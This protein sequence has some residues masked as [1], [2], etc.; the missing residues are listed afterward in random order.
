MRHGKI[1]KADI[2]TDSKGAYEPM[3][4]AAISVALEGLPYSDVVIEQAIEK[5]DKE[6]PGLIHSDSKYVVNDIRQWLKDRL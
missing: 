1:I 2:T 3:L 5:I 6:V 4:T